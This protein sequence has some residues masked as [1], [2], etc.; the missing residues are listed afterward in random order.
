MGNLKLSA[1][2]RKR[3]FSQASDGKRSESHLLSGDSY[4]ISF[5]LGL[6]LDELDHLIDLALDLKR[7]VFI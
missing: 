1:F 6:L 2:E 7:G 3:C 4:F 5:L